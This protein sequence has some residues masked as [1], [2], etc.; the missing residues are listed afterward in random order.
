MTLFFT[1]LGA[2]TLGTFSANAVLLWVIGSLAKRQEAKQKEE[3]LQLQQG[4][5]EMVQRERARLENY[6]RMEG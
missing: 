4:Y 2:V 5:L 6:A 1:V 3:L